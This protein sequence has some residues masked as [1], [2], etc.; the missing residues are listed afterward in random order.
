MRDLDVEALASIARQAG[1]AIMEVR[2]NGFDVTVKADQSP[3]TTADTRSNRV[4]LDGLA[5]FFPGEPV[6]CE[7]TAQAPPELRRQWSRCF[8]VDPLDGTKEFA[9]GS[10]EFCVCI[11]LVAQ[12]EPVF[13]VIHAPVTDTL[14]AGG[15]QWGAWRRQADGPIESIRVSPP[16]P[17]EA[18]A[19]LGSVSHPDPRL[20][21]Y[22]DRLPVGYRLVTRGS[23]LKFCAVAEGKAH[24]YP[25][26]N[27]TWEW[28]TA[29]GH[30]ILLGAGG[31]LTGPGGAAFPYNKHELRNGPFLARAWKGSDPY[32]ELLVFP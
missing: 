26:L 9:R 6:I 31:S 12:G 29:A 27:P 5:R 23:A 10:D 21:A 2:Q 28:D 8:V 20:A 30:A 24:V 3:L 22:L 16:A 15:P 17:G 25:R 19:V 7:E 13:G 32:P 11:A 18:L 1:V 4:I 14:Y